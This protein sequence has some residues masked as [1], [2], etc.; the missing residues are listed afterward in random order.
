MGTTGLRRVLQHFRQVAGRPQVEALA[1]GDLL[2]QFLQAN[3]GAAFA[4]L[5]RRHGPMVLGVCRRVLGND[6]DAEDAFQA[7]FLVLVRR[8]A[9]VRPR[10]R[11]GNW[12]YGVACRTAREARRAAARRRAKEAL[13]MPRPHSA[14]DPWAELRLV[15]DRELARL[16][17]RYRVVLVL[18]DLERR[19]RKAAAEHLGWHE[20]TVSSRLSRA[21]ELLARRLR[22]HGAILSGGLLVAFLG[23]GTGAAA[24]PAPLAAQTV[25]AATLLAAG[26]AAGVL[27]PQTAAL[28]ERT[29]RAMWLA[30]LKTLGAVVAVLGVA[31]AAAFRSAAQPPAAGGKVTPAPVLAA[32]K[33]VEPQAKAAQEEKP[34]I[35][36][37]EL[38]PVVVRTVPVS[39]DTEVDAAKVTEI[40]VTFSKGM[41]D[42]SW[43]W[44]SVSKESFPKTT[45]KP[46]YDK[47]G[48]TCVLPVKLEA[49]KTYALWVNSERFQNFKDADGH[50]AV[51]YL[52]VFE[53]KAEGK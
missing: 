8:A 10:S 22:R 21:R 27:T 38:P 26:S 13:A 5:V 3:D 42:E 15:L 45:G 9:D 48:K 32:A 49:G 40:R 20:G 33:Q 44:S 35:S 18:C 31:A 24:V 39:G 34:G 30:K 16:P 6:H 19:T 46:R 1:D 2:E 52:L 17:E 23:S 43:S 37:K 41:T 28:V 25:E 29:V 51:P 53:T 36:V 11:L 50:P 47:D 12:L 14:E 7:T 4:E